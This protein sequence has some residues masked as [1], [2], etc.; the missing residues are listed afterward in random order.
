MEKWTGEHRALAIKAYYKNGDSFAQVQRLFVRHFRIPRNSPM[1]F[2]HAIK[3]WVQNFEETG[4]ALSEKS[5][6]SAKTVR[7]PENVVA[8]REAF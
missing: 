1:S 2:A 3:T 4:S 8:V 6:G 5:P 7:T